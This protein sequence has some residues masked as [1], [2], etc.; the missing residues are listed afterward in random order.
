LLDGVGGYA[1][2][3]EGIAADLGKG[4]IGRKWVKPLTEAI[5]RKSCYVEKAGNLI[6]GSGRTGH[7]AL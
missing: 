5:D 4:W 2:L 7:G 6:I 3:P 1:A